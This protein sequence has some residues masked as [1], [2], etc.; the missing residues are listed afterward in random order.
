MSSYSFI[1]IDLPLDGF[2]RSCV[3]KVRKHITLLF[4]LSTMCPLKFIN[5]KEK[6]RI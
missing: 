4:M 5:L 3:L 2:L 6:E 1:L